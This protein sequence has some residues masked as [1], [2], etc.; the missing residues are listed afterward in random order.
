VA[1]RKNSVAL[2]EVISK[3]KEKYGEAR[4]G[5]PGWAGKQEPA[6]A[7]AGLAAAAA[8]PTPAAPG[9]TPAAAEPARLGPATALRRGLFG[10][11]APGEVVFAR[12]GPRLRVSLSYVACTVVVVGLMAAM[13]GAF[14][15]GRV[16]VG[17]QP[18]KPTVEGG[19]R[20]PFRPEVA[21][22][23]GIE[24]PAAKEGARQPGKYYLVIQG[25]GGT[26]EA[27]KTEGTRIMQ[28]CQ[29][30]GEPATVATLP[31]TT[32]AKE[33]Y[34]VWSLT[35]FDSSSS[36]AARKYALHIEEL[37]KKYFEK[38]QTYRFQQHNR[39]KFD[40]W[41]ELCRGTRTEG[42]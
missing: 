8:G 24:K 37:G 32:R 18:G 4:L 35:G 2:F 40:P 36:D 30:N 26:T 10:S 9:P 34:I 25:L 31:R 15:L 14:L 7:A 39:D 41:F 21:T 13:C 23:R 5:V 22:T 42:R 19:M 1:K 17:P 3:G 29:Q 6:P 27:E 20:V 16:S 11:K 38:Y 33:Q 12:E 28:F